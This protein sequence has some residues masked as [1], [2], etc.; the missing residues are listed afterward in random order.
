MRGELAV[1]LL[2]RS[3]TGQNKGGKT[4]MAGHGES[5]TGHWICR[6]DGGTTSNYRAEGTGKGIWAELWACFSLLGSAG[7]GVVQPQLRGEE[8]ESQPQ[9]Q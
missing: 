3:E 7:V 2:A 5:V 6:C 8:Q 1:G 9:F 4:K